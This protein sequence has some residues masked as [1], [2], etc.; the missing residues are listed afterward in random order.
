MVVDLVVMAVG[1]LLLVTGIGG[2]ESMRQLLY[3]G[4]SDL[5]AQSNAPLQTLEILVHA[6]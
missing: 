4:S 3:G 6:P 5:S 1:L 2:M